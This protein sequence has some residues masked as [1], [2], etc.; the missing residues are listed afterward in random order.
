[1][2]MERQLPKDSK[3]KNVTITKTKTNKYFVSI[4][5]EY[6]KE[7]EKVTPETYIGLDYSPKHMYIDS[8]G[9]T[10]GVPK[11]YKQYEEK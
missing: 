8:N 7:I 11:P 9:D 10:P 5:F 4:N 2:R 3:I 6:Y 1:M